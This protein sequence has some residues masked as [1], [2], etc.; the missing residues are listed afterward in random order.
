MTVP[1]ENRAEVNIREELDVVTVDPLFLERQRNRYASRGLAFVVLLNGLAAIALL[2]GLAHGTPAGG[3]V[4]AFADAM[5]VFGIGAALGLLS[6]FVAYVSRTLRI[7][8]REFL[9][10]RRPLRW[11]AIAAAIAGAVCFVA[12]LNM[13]RVSAIPQESPKAETKAQ[14]ETTPQPTQPQ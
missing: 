11:L 14:P 5:L 10:W 8:W 2:I 3:A 4:K 13:V 9:T 1:T 7:E 6:A 12:G